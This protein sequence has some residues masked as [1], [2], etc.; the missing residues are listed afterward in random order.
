MRINDVADRVLTDGLSVV[1]AAE[2]AAILVL[3]RGAI[4]CSAAVSKGPA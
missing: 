2:R 3:Q 4:R 1:A